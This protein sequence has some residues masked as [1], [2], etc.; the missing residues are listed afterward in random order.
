MAATQS[1]SALLKRYMPEKLI[2]NDFGKKNY[3]WTKC[4]KDQ[5][6]AGGI[7]EIPLLEA[8]FSTMQFGTLAATNDIAEMEVAMGTING[9][10]ELWNSIY[11]READLFRHGDMEA[12]YLKIMP[13]QVDAFTSRIQEK[14]ST[15]FLAGG[16]IATAEGDGTASGTIVVDNPEL[17]QKGEKVEIVDDDTAATTGYIRAIDLNTKTLTIYNARSGGAALDLSGV[18]PAGYKVSANAKIRLVGTGAEK[19]LSL[20]EACLPA[21]LGGSDTLYGKT[22]TDFMTLQSYR[23]DGTGWTVSTI[24][25]DV[26]NFIYNVQKLGRGRQNEILVNFGM[27]KNISKKLEASKRYVTADKKAGYGFVSVSILGPEGDVTITALRNMPKNM[28]FAIDWKGVS[29]AGKEFFKKKLYN[30][31]DFFMLRDSTG[32]AFITDIALRG[33]FVVKPALVSVVH[34]IPTAVSA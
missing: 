24:L 27:F 1:Y 12:S 8:G 33:D 4:E 11:V 19:F 26:M 10:K 21:S 13:E 15:H 5:S 29:F 22:K 20:P 34:S 2:E 23:E 3:I 17:F 9:H 7:Y 25:D 31:D 18:S 30:G 28:A 14:V 6:W 16:K 32:P